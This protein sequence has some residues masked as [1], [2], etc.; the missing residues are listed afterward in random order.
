[1]NERLAMKMEF[2]GKENSPTFVGA[3]VLWGSE[4][5]ATLATRWISIKVAWV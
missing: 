3:V 1:M 4:L 2:G 5:G